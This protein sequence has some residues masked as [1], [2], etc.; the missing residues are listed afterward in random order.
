VTRIVGTLQAD[1]I[2][3]VQHYSMRPYRVVRPR[4]GIRKPIVETQS[5][6]FLMRNSRAS[7]PADSDA[8]RNANESLAADGHGLARGG[9]LTTTI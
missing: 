9:A 8:R 1:T 3:V 5:H 2:L 4:H 7:G 6:A